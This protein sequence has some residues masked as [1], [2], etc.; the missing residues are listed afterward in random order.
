M[1][2]HDV[3]KNL[4][5]K[6]P[7]K[8]V[9]QE[10][11]VSLSLVYK[12]AEAPIVGSGASNPL[13]RIE[14]ITRLAQDMAPLA[15]LCER[16]NGSFVGHPTAEATTTDFLRG[17][18]RIMLE[19]G[20]LLAEFSDLRD[21][22]TPARARDMR[23]RWEQVKSVMEKYIAAAEQNR[24]ATQPPAA[25]APATTPKPA[26]KKPA[27]RITPARYKRSLGARP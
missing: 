22:I 7:A 15:W 11:G 19:L 23:Q 12:W 8:H 3:V 20:Q 6:I 25:A 27:P 10:L 26:P 18:S 4:L 9:A 17:I 21:N 24:L 2:S 13:D 1:E 16:F 14:V 5:K